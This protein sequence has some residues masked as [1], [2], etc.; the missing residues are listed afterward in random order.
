MTDEEKQRARVVRAAAAWEK[1]KA[2]VEYLGGTVQGGRS[3][4][5]WR[6]NL[7]APDG[8]VWD[9]TGDTT[10]L[11]VEWRAGDTLGKQEAVLD[12]LSRVRHGVSADTV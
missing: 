7:D 4:R 5:W 1:V 3:G 2:E 6:F 10:V 9:A 11:V 12:A 8:Y